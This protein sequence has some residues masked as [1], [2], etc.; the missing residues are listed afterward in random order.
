MKDKRSEGNTRN[1]A[2]LLYTLSLFLVGVILLL[3]FGLL[4]NQSVAPG[5][6]PERLT[7][8]AY[9]LMI[10][11]LLALGAQALLVFKGLIANIDKDRQTARELSEKVA[12]LSVID[13]LTKAFNRYK[14]NS[15]MTR[16]LENVRR[17]RSVLS[18]IMFDIDGFRTIN[19]RHGYD[20]GDKLLYHL[21]RFVNKRV[22]KTDYLFRWRGGKFIILAPHIDHRVAEEVAEKLRQMV[23]SMPFGSISITISLGVTQAAGRDT[24]ETFLQRLQGGLTSAKNKGR[25]CVIGNPPNRL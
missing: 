7:K 1:R 16:E 14:F 15:V 18:G 5:I 17:Y 25:N 9:L 13:D 20:A 4:Y 8:F 19:E 6:P 10:G 21:A 3:D 12:Q 23:E 2:I 11:G 22:R 24:L